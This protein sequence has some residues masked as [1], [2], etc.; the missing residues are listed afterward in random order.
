M[1]I[2][3]DV[4]KQLGYI[5]LAILQDAVFGLSVYQSVMSFFGFYHK[6]KPQLRKPA[7]RFA[8]LVP[9]HNE[10][11][12][13]SDVLD[14]L[15]AQEY[16]HALYDVYVVADN[17]TDDT[18]AVARE[19]GAIVCERED[20]ALT[21]KGHAIGWLLS[22]IRLS[23]KN[24]DMM[25]MF[26]AD[27]RVSPNFLQEIDRYAQAGH[28]AIQ[29]YLDIKNPGDNWISLSYAIGYWYTNRFLDLARSNMGL[30][31][32]LGGTGS[33]MAMSL[34]DEIGWNPHSITEDLEFTIQCILRGV[35]PV[36]AWDARVYDEKPTDMKVSWYQRMRWMRGHFSLMF[37]YSGA[38]WK[39]LFR[40]FDMA[41]FDML[42]Y[43]GQ[44]IWMVFSYLLTFVYLGIQ[45]G[46][47]T[48]LPRWASAGSIAPW[49]WVT[50]S[51]LSWFAPPMLI[52]ALAIEKVKPKYWWGVFGFAIYGLTYVPIDF[53]A[54]FTR[55]DQTWFHT[56]HKNAGLDRS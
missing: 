54:L 45:V 16:P 44:P 23:G 15:A 6:R 28:R 37:Q 48:T 33:C 11:H 5:L 35:H 1:R 43:L 34:V 40:H 2:T 38:L 17:C 14:S 46:N 31:A 49:I 13:I 36:W 53:I 18:A 21:G 25:A 7:T 47:I 10:G 32:M 55:N 4:I 51:I 8:V 29:G 12:V 19:H 50:V 9:A 26:D 22:R 20:T 41:S 24:Y 56:A 39:R 3:T 42:V 27:N 30:A 52:A